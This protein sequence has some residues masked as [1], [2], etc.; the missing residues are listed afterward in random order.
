MNQILIVPINHKKY[1]VF[2]IIELTIS[3]L[4]IV[5]CLVY[6]LISYC[7][8]DSSNQNLLD[9]YQISKLYA[10]NSITLSLTNTPQIIGTLSIPKINIHYS[11]ISQLDDDLLKK[12]IC[13]FYGPN[14]NEIG[15][16]CIAGHN[17]NNDT[18]FSNLH[19]LEIG[20]TIFV[21]DNLSKVI[22]YR[23]YKKYETSF[24]DTSCTLQDTFGKKELTLVTCNNL[25]G[26][27][28]IV[29]AV[30]KVIIK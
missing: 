4:I 29:K 17:Y 15:N 20:D 25:N 5:G 26:N 22:E 14:P 7:F 6:M 13:K 27:R 24:T 23:I 9:S 18:F 30:G 2:F 12:S 10:N 28:I 3:I 21:E 19:Q 1:I 16:L 8:A 11:I